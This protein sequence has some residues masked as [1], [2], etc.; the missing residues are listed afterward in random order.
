VVLRRR[1]G[2]DGDYEVLLPHN[3]PG[4]YE[5]R[6]PGLDEPYQ[7]RVDV[8]PGHEQEESG[9]AEEALRQAAQH[10]GGR[11]Y[12]EDDLT[13]LPEQVQPQKTDFVLRQEVLLWNPLILVLFVGLITTEWVV[14]KFSNLS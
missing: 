2:R 14:R 10:S 3:A 1:Q 12:R 8:P 9:L 6:I 5:L 11:F 4:R 7:Y 13:Q